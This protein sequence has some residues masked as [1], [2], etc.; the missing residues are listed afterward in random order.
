MEKVGSPARATV[1]ITLDFDAVS[2]WMVW[3]AAG[4]RA[5]SRG[6]FGPKV[7]AP[8]LLAL[9]DKLDIPTTWFTPGHTA[10]TYPDITRRVAERGHE[11]G[12]HGYHHTLDVTDSSPGGTGEAIATEDDIKANML[13]AKQAIE[14][15]TG[16]DPVGVRAPAGDYSATLFQQALDLGFIYDSSNCGE[17]YP[18]WCRKP[19]TLNWEGPNTE[20][21]EIDLV[22]CPLSFELDDFNYFMFNYGN[23]ELPGLM[24]PSFIMEGVWKAQFDYM[25]DNCPGGI[26]NLTMH[27]QCTGWGFRAAELEKLLRYFQSK[28]GVRFATVET[29]ARE[30]IASHELPSKRK[31]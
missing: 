28:P 23:P 27:P 7:G 15:V 4:A 16:F 14:R 30:F 26:W 2:I 24:P 20:G 3:K 18:T 25:Y 17:F 6:E 12:I 29:V 21:E 19:D 13:K 8:R 10:E 31:K 1:C 22:E 5:L 9:F 11:I